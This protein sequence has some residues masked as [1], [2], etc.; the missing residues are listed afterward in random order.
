MTRWNTWRIGAVDFLY[1]SL[2]FTNA[3]NRHPSRSLGAY[4]ATWFILSSFADACMSLF[5]ERVFN[6]NRLLMSLYPWQSDQFRSPFNPKTFPASLCL[7]CGAF[8]AWHWFG[9]GRAEPIIKQ[10]ATIRPKRLLAFCTAAFSIAAMVIS[11]TVPEVSVSILALML[12][13]FSVQPIQNSS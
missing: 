12:W 2:Y 5:S 10:F 11:R 1:V 3:S 4:M 6:V 13:G 8:L 9:R 7:I